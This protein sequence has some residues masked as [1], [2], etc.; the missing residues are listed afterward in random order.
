MGGPNGMFDFTKVSD[1]LYDQWEKGMSTWWDQVLENPAFL[2]M[3]GENLAAGSKARKAY[4]EALDRGLERAHLPTR[5]DLI[6]TARIV[7]MLE[8]KVLG[9]EDRLLALADRLDGIEREALLARVEAAE[10]RVELG[11]RLARIEDMLEALLG[12]GAAAAPG[13]AGGARRRGARKEGEK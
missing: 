1:E 13:Q 7:S 4:E 2:G 11:E 3:L 8:D 6:R 5:G 10:A 12:S 9:L